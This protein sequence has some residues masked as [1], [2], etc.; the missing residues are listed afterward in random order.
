MSELDKQLEEILKKGT[1][2][3]TGADKVFF[4]FDGIVD[5]IK[6][7]FIDDGWR[8]Y[9]EVYQEML[10]IRPG[11]ESISVKAGDVMTKEEWERQAI[12]DGWID[13]ES[14]KE[15]IEKMAKDT[16]AALDMAIEMAKRAMGAR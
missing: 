15:L 9:P 12:K 16:K 4:T 2:A 10:V 13:L 1:F 8:Q 7:A 14:Q 11:G 3:A 6:Q 5:A